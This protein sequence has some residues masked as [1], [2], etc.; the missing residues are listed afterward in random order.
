[1][2]TFGSRR[3]EKGNDN[4]GLCPRAP[5]VLTTPLCVHWYSLCL[6]PGRMLCPSYLEKSLRISLKSGICNQDVCILLAAN[7]FV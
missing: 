6:S 7:V 2:W 3:Y 4:A 1:M 5:D